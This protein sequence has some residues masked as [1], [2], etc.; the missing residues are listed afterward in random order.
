MVRE[1]A[2]FC[3]EVNKVTTNAIIRI[4]LLANKVGKET[5]RLFSGGGW[6]GDPS[7]QQSS[8]VR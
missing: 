6:G 8:Q 4:C 1:R 2:Y 3:L 7:L 5:I